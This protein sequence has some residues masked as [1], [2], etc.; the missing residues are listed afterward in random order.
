M[1]P[2]SQQRPQAHVEGASHVAL[3]LRACVEGVAQ[4]GEVK[5]EGTQVRLWLLC[6]AQSCAH[7]AISSELAGTRPH[8]NLLRCVVAAACWQV[9]VE[10][11]KQAMVCSMCKHT[12]KA[13]TT[14]AADTAADLS[15]CAQS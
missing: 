10:Q 7:K 9:D 15:V 4:H 12:E 14:V 11:H 5:D 1:P 2:S 13:A 3:D 6:K 8:H